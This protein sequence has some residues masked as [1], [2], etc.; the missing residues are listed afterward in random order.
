MNVLHDT[1]CARLNNIFAENQYPYIFTIHQTYVPTDAQ[2]RHLLD[3][4]WQTPAPFWS[5]LAEADASVVC[6][7]TLVASA[8]EL[9]AQ[10]RYKT[11]PDISLRNRPGNVRDD[12]LSVECKSR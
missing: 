7:Q 8:E 3:I 1:A 9:A 6:M 4:L 12:K 10:I 11:I 2:V 5:M